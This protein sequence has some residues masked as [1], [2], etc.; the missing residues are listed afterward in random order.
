MIPK[1][2]DKEIIGHLPHLITLEYR[3]TGGFKVVYRGVDKAGK[4]EAI[5]A[6]YIPEEKDGFEPEL[7]DQLVARAQRE[8]EALQLC[9]SPCIV[10]LGQVNP[11]LVNFGAGKYLLYSEE[12]IPGYPLSD[13][14]GKQVPDIRTLYA[15]TSFLLDVIEEMIR[16]D[17]LHRDI[18][19][20]NIMVTDLGQRPYV[21]LDMG[22]AYKMQGTQLT[23]ISG[24]PGTLRYMAPELFSP[25]YKDVMDFRCDL[26]SA[27]L[28]LYEYASG[29]NPFAPRPENPFVTQY[30]IL[31]EKPQPLEGLRNDLPVKYCRIIDRCMKKNPA[32][33]YSNINQL[34]E[35]IEEALS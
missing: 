7:I 26:Y 29:M 33:R 11:R 25:T 23:Q 22:I 6:I 15:V 17:H 3:A 1:P 27:G 14:V 13:I 20:A 5:K 2:E 19:P 24:P 28:S 34:R 21:I 31:K 32:L 18:K 10:K 8:I 4:V 30:R 12:F 9:V 16:I 35:E